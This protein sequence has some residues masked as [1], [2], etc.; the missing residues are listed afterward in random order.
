[1]YNVTLNQKCKKCT[2]CLLFVNNTDKKFFLVVFFGSADIRPRSVVLSPAAAIAVH[3]HT[4]VQRSDAVFMMS[5]HLCQ[6]HHRDMAGRGV[7]ATLN[8]SLRKISLLEKC[9]EI[10]ILGLE[11]PHF[12]G[13]QGQ[14]RTF[15]HP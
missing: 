10:Q 12:A 2:F 1:M 11:I 5:W 15:E 9:P 7:I 3:A 4:R 13:I 6:W 8:F 14:N